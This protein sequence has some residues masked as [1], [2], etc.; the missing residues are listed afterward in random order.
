MISELFTHKLDHVSLTDV[1]A[2]SV[3]GVLTGIATTLIGVGVAIAPKVRD[4]LYK[5]A[6]ETEDDKKAEKYIYSFSA[7]DA[8][9]KMQLGKFLK[10]IV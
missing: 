6:I 3:P 9:A 5:K 4:N 2:P 1:M 8:A 10:S 7:V